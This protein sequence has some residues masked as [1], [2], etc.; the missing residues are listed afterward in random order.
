MM[1]CGAVAVRPAD[2][3]QLLAAIPVDPEARE[4]G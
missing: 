1:D 3:L 2:S 4:D